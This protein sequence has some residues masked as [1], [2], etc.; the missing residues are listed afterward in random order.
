MRKLLILTFFLPLMAWAQSSLPP[1][2]ETGFKH[3]CFGTTTL[4]NGDKYVGEF[5]GGNF[6]GQGMATSA[7][8]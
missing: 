2:P 4:P 3:N 7:R 8:I 1:C 6:H 5:K